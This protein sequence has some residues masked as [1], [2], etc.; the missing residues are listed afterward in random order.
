LVRGESRHNRKKYDFMI[1][2]EGLYEILHWIKRISACCRLC[3]MT[4]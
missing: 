4:E 2:V 1:G 3:L